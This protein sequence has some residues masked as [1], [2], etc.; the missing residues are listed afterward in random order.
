MMV[1][2][3]ILLFVSLFNGPS[4]AYAITSYINNSA[5]YSVGTKLSIAMKKRQNYRF[6]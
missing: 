4:D 2:I 5:K 6:F 1:S 3:S